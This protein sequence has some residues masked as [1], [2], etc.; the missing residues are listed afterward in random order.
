MTLEQLAVNMQK[1]KKNELQF[2]LY[3][4]YKNILN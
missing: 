4:I 3:I 1:I 2:I